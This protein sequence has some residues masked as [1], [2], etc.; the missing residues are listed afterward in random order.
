MNKEELHLVLG[1]PASQTLAWAEAEAQV[2]EVVALGSDP[3]RGSVLLRVREDLVITTHSV[4]TQ[5]N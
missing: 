5:L 3:A 4:E 2:P 1:D